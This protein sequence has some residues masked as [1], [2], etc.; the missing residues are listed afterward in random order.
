MALLKFQ[1]PKILDN[2]HTYI[3]SFAEHDH[4][5]QQA[6]KNVIASLNFLGKPGSWK[7]VIA[8]SWQQTVRWES[9]V[10]DFA[11]EHPGR[12]YFHKNLFFSV[13]VSGQKPVC[14]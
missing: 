4:L 7:A 8:C 14:N 5:P 11:K 3:T 2:N 12:V 13:T 10:A 1:Y 9:V 6:M